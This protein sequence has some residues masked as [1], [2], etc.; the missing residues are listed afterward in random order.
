MRKSEKLLNKKPAVVFIYGPVA[1]GKLTVAKI[2]SRKLGYKLV[3]NHHLNDFIAEVFER[4]SYHSHAMKDF[5]RY[6]LLEN[7]VKAGLNIVTTHC[8]SHDFVS[9]TGLT[10][11]T[12][13]KTLEKRL[14]KL[15]AKF[16]PVFLKADNE[17]LLKR[18]G[19]KSRKK[20]KKLISKKIFKKLGYN[21]HIAP[22]LKNN[23][24]I[25]N[26]KIS[27]QK[28]ANMIIKHF[29]IKSK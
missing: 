15:G 7:T 27:P 3:H 16:Y 23:L 28:V 26:T 8:Y 29:K 25:D 9:R 24:I 5:L 2:L 18:V 6:Y 1:V 14:T 22:N 17:T 21:Q 19:M 4:G 10:D 12:Y 13:V 11:P 20:F